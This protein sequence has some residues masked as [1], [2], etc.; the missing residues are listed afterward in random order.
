MLYYLVERLVG[1]CSKSLLSKLLSAAFAA[2]ESRY[3]ENLSSQL[4]RVRANCNRMLESSD[5]PNDPDKDG[6]ESPSWLPSSSSELALEFS[7]DGIASNSGWKEFCLVLRLV[8]GWGRIDCCLRGG[9][10]GICVVG[11]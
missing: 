11:M 3:P 7:S 4:S 6:V 1:K 5:D 10:G 8:L 2:N 9:R